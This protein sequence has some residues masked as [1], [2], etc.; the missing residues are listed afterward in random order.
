MSGRGGRNNG[1][2][3]RGGKGRGRGRGRGQKLTGTTTSTKKGLCDALSGNV[4]GYGQE[5]AADQMQTL[6]RRLLT[7][8]VLLML[9]TSAMSCRT[10][11]L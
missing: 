9:K 3:G 6:G 4:F 2:G 11:Q 10:K 1:R 7:T 5:A 8:S